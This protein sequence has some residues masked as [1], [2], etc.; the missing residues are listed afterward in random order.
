MRFRL[1]TMERFREA[2]ATPP[3]SPREAS[4]KPPRSHRGPTSMLRPFEAQPYPLVLKLNASL[5]AFHHPLSHGLSL[6]Q[7]HG[8]ARFVEQ[9]SAKPGEATP[10]SHSL[11]AKPREANPSTNSGPAKPPA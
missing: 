5:A 1:E 10:R 4:A 9:T 2:S 7:Q 8:G 6:I 11:A 3:R